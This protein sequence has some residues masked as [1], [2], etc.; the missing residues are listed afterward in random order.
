MALEG[1]RSGGEGS[2]ASSGGAARAADGIQHSLPRYSVSALILAGIVPHLPQPEARGR[3]QR[4][5]GIACSVPQGRASSSGTLPTQAPTNLP[6][7]PGLLGTAQHGTAPAPSTPRCPQVLSAAWGQIV[8]ERRQQHRPPAR[9]AAAAPG[10]A[11][12]EGGGDPAPGAD[13]RPHG[14]DPAP[15]ADARP[16][17]LPRRKRGWK[18]AA[19]QPAQFSFRHGNMQSHRFLRGLQN[20]LY[21]SFTISILKYIALLT[22]EKA[23]NCYRFLTSSLWLE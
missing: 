13:A 21:L 5:P 17:G 18:G 3:R 10:E 22:S 7:A 4:L 8:T 1:P 23:P 9:R 2:C 12:P 20:R 6:E 15:G 16:R 14:G 19:V 11:R